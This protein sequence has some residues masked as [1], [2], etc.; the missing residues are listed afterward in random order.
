MSLR[1]SRAPVCSFEYAG[2]GCKSGPAGFKAGQ[3]FTAVYNRASWL[4]SRPARFKTGRPA[5][6]P[7]AGFQAGQV[8][9]RALTYAWEEHTCM[10]V[11]EKPTDNV[12]CKI[13]GKS[14]FSVCTR[15]TVFWFL[16]CLYYVQYFSFFSTWYLRM[17]MYTHVYHAFCLLLTLHQSIVI[18]LLQLFFYKQSDFIF[19]TAYM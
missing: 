19:N 16:Q 17:Y 4:Y 15:Y 18:L 7:A 3:A 13:E 12:G 2:P 6:K 1:R 10:C 8:Y 11:M 9:N 14:F 5:I